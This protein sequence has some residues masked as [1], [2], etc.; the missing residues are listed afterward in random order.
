MSGGGAAP[1]SSGIKSV[2]LTEVARTRGNTG[3]S[4]CSRGGNVLGGVGRIGDGDRYRELIKMD[5]IVFNAILTE[6]RAPLA[7]DPG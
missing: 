1:R 7:Y 4:S 5:T 6:L 3:G 2:V